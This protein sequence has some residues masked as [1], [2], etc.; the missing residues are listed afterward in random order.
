MR[1][2]STPSL[3]AAL[4]LAAGLAAAPAAAQPLIVT[5]GVAQV[6]KGDQFDYVRARNDARIEMSGGEVDDAYEALRH[7][8]LDD[9]SLQLEQQ[10]TALVSGGLLRGDVM[11]FDEAQ[12]AMTGGRS[13][14]LHAYLNAAVDVSGGEPGALYGYGDAVYD[15]T[16]GHS[17]LARGR[18]NAA[19]TMSGG[20]VE[21]LELQDAS[22]LTQTAGLVSGPVYLSGQ[23]D[24][25]LEGEVDVA[26]AGLSGS[27][28]LI[29]R[30]EK[31]IS[32]GGVE[33]LDE[34]ELELVGVGGTDIGIVARDNSRV[35]FSNSG[36]VVSTRLY[37]QASLIQESGETGWARLHDSSRFEMRGGSVRTLSLERGGTLLHRG[38]EIEFLTTNETGGLVEIKGGTIGRELLLEGDASLEIEAAEFLT[39]GLM[40][41]L[42]LPGVAPQRLFE[43]EEFILTAGTPGYSGTHGL[44]LWSFFVLNTDGTDSLY[45]LEIPTSPQNPW[46]GSARFVRK[47]AGS[48][49]LVEDSGIHNFAPGLNNDLRAALFSG[50]AVGRQNAGSLPGSVVVSDSARFEFEDGF[51]GGRIIALDQSRL[52]IK[53]GVAISENTFSSSILAY[54]NANVELTGGRVSGV[55]LY[56]N[57]TASCLSGDTEARISAREQA[58]YEQTAGSV[59]SVGVSGEASATIAGGVIRS[60]CS[61]DEN[62]SV[63]MTGGSVLDEVYVEDGEFLFEGGLINNVRVSGGEFL[64]VDGL[65]AG[66][67]SRVTRGLLHVQGGEIDGDL[68]VVGGET[69]ISGGRV[70]RL[71]ADDDNDQRIV[72]EQQGRVGSVEFT[73]GGLLEMLGG[74]VEEDIEIQRRSRLE[75]RGG[76]VLG[77]VIMVFT[78]EVLIEGRSFSYDHDMNPDTPPREIELGA[79]SSLTIEP[80][81]PLLTYLE[82]ERGSFEGLPGFTVEYADGTVSSFDLLG[83]V[84]P[85]ELGERSS[86]TWEG[87]LILRRSS[88]ADLNNDGFVNTLDLVLMFN[89]WGVSCD[90]C[91]ADLNSDG[92]VNVAD[93]SLLLSAWGT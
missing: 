28:R 37:D 48:R 89:E 70:Q 32:F 18:V 83:P 7:P 45:T 73:R 57:A 58:Y 3:P 17:G 51:I 54:G 40:S 60:R 22:T 91:A 29:V 78:C 69:R 64:L 47:P 21:G 93:L 5:A 26:E 61:V 85:R 38:G 67:P 53:G 39:L 65:V 56:S 33:A 82:D 49:V 9:T 15:I 75:M 34:S 23:A 35:R 84:F 24:A 2:S 41:G 8:G 76:E 6:M 1:H 87:E 52:E 4:V 30:P 71:I 62:G 44:V 80:G 10:S 81:D 12:F 90:P 46:D 25:L 92:F 31:T 74:T 86:Y 16:G 19:Y 13:R 27:S 43:G 88:V 68:E 50:D 42:E 20:I 14:D 66:A 55:V 77:D 11:L 59:S 79:E 36:E 63:L 72:M